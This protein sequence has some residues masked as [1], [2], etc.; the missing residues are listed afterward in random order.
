M[1][2]LFSTYPIAFSVSVI[3]PLITGLVLAVGGYA[4]LKARAESDNQLKRIEKNTQFTADNLPDLKN[5]IDTLHRYE[6][7]LTAS[8]QKD[9]TLT[10]VLS[11]YIRMSNATE[12]LE[13]QRGAKDLEERY[14][15][16]QEVLDILSSNLT[17]VHVRDDLPTHPLIINLGN[18]TFRVLFIVPMRI[19][20]KIKFDGLPEDTE[21]NIIDKSKFGF[22]VTFE[23]KANP[24]N[25]F[26]FS[27]DARYYPPTL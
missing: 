19:P 3:L 13:E 9:A 16:A 14:G 22:S 15:L 25:N 18:N 21:P 26:G 6:Q 24:V 1:Q 11:Q 23:P 8:G 4:T 12:K 20:P 5:T 27:A 10:A 17:P 7:A 2:Q